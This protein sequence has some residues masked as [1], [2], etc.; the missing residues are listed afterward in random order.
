MKQDSGLTRRDTEPR[1]VLDPTVNRSLS[2]PL[3]DQLRAAI[4]LMI[5]DRGLRPGDVLPSEHQLCKDFTVSRTVVRQALAQLDN[6]GL[7]RRI[8]GKGTY[9]SHPKTGE[10]LM[11][12]L[13]GLYEDVR[14][15]GG[16]VRSDVLR[17]AIVPASTEVAGQ[18]GILAKSPV[19]VLQRMRFVDDEPWALSTAWLP[20]HVGKHTV[21][22]DMTR[23]SLYLVLERNGISGA[24]GWRSVEAVLA[25]EVSAA[26][27][28]TQPGSALLKLRSVRRDEQGMPFEYFEALHRGD[29]SRF[30]FELTRDETFARIRT[31]SLGSD[32]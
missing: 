13:M 4:L 8:K 1:A 22:V 19:M 28:E 30:E 5:S 21:D 9:V 31:N 17:H 32:G 10:R 15:R 2:S 16:V 24:T 25:D 23:E 18:L 7:V 12:T 11:H 29:H 6:E 26:R 14:I 3:Y 20:E 27:L